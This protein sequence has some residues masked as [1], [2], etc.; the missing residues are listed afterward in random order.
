MDIIDLHPAGLDLGEGG[1][2]DTA[3]T[4]GEC[5]VAWTCRLAKKFL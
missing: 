3:V 1:V 2:L 5:R 4:G